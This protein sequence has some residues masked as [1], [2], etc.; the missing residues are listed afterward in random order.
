MLG[1]DIH[2][3][4][5]QNGD[6]HRAHRVVL[7]LDDVLQQLGGAL[8]LLSHVHRAG[9]KA[10]GGAG[11]TGDDVGVL[12]LHHIGVGHHVPVHHV[13]QRHTGVAGQLFQ[14]LQGQL[15]G[16]VEAK[17]GGAHALC[18]KQG[19]QHVH[20]GGGLALLVAGPGHPQGAVAQLSGGQNGG[21][22][23]GHADHAVDVYRA[24]SRPQLGTVF[25]YQVVKFRLSGGWHVQ[26]QRADT[27]LKYGNRCIHVFHVVLL[28]FGW[29]SV[30]LAQSF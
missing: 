11:G 22:A 25:L 24:L 14:L 10:G 16:T 27:P 1:E 3:V 23:L 5:L 26:P 12:F 30:L 21:P 9:D 8:Q 20:P 6:L 2:V 15:L 4:L 18:H 19:G 7:R 17:G 29:V 28:H 13:K